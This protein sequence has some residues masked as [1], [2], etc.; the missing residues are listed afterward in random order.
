M[1]LA[2]AMPNV[3]V[4]IIRTKAEI[5][6]LKTGRITSSSRLEVAPRTLPDGRLLAIARATAALTDTQ[7]EVHLSIP[8][9][10]VIIA[11]KRVGA[12]L[13]S[14]AVVVP[15]TRTEVLRAVVQVMT[16]KETL[17]TRP[18]IATF[19]LGPSAIP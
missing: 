17:P 13:A 15:R 1:A 4:L 19:P 8:A 11:P 10:A 6:I 9:S 16:M 3:P 7:T 14:R 18:A 2:V 5:K 12:R